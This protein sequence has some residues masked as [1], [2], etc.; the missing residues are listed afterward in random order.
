MR[1]SPSV[2]QKGMPF[3]RLRDILRKKSSEV[4][5]KMK[6]FWQKTGNKEDYQKNQRFL[7]DYFTDIFKCFTINVL[8]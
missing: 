8:S 1:P 7:K 6:I 4:A 5:E 2:S 3:E